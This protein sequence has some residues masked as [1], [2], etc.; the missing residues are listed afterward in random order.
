MSEQEVGSIYY[1]T[2]AGHT[3]LKEE[4]DYLTTVKRPEIA[5]RLRESQG[6]GEFSEDNSELDEVK[7][8]QSMVE[9]RIAELRALFGNVQVLNDDMIPTDKVGMGSV[10]KIHDLEFDD[11][12]ELRLVT[13]FEADPDLDA[14]SNESPMGMA[15][16]GHAAGEEF[17]FEAPDGK[18]R[19]KILSI[20]R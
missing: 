19:Y 8:E 9:N 16:Y 6:H 10:V 17:Q 11:E 4:L 5:E 20:R 2:P 18:K 13:S 3:R 12:F 1:L 14:V 7:S 15:M